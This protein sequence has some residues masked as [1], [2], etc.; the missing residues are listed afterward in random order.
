MYLAKLA[1]F[2]SSDCELWSFCI[3]KMPKILWVY[4]LFFCKPN[5]MLYFKPNGQCKDFFFLLIFKD[6]HISYFYTKS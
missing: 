6:D 4:I 5:F 1:A 2:D 3:G